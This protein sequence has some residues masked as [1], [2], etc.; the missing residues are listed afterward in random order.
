MPGLCGSNLILIDNPP[1]NPSDRQSR[2]TFAPSPL[3]DDYGGVYCRQWIKS[4]GRT[5]VR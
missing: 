4:L 5:I 2:L 3:T 1:A